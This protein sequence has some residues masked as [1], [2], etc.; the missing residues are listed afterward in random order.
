[1]ITQEHLCDLSRQDLRYV[2]SFH[3]LDHSHHIPL[4]DK[5]FYTFYY[6][7]QQGEIAYV[8]QKKTYAI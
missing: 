8:L 2:Q 4:K 1:M 3:S 7:D 5:S 6:L